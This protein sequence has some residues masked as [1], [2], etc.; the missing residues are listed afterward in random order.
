MPAEWVMNAAHINYF[1]DMCSG[2]ESGSYLRLIDSVY[3]ST[4][5]LRVTKKEEEEVGDESRTDPD[6]V[7]VSEW[8]YRGTSII[9][10]RPTLGPYIRPTPRAL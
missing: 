2:S 7:R 10:N 3:H 6:A 9:R 4:L 5:V 1:T 8:R